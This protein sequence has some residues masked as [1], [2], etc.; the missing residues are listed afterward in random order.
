MDRAGAAPDRALAL[1]MSGGGARAA[2]QV[3]VLR[4]LAR[5]RPAL[6]VS[7]LTG[8]SAGAINAVHLAHHSGSFHEAMESLVSA[9]RSLSIDQVFRTDV[10]YLS[11]NVLR[12][13]ARLLSGGGDFAPRTRGLVDTE[14]LRRFLCNALGT[15]DGRLPGIRRNIE[16]GRLRAVAI[17]T[18][19]YAT[20]QSV[21]WCE[22][23]AVTPWTRPHRQSR[24]AELTV[25]HVMASTALPLIFPAVKLDPEW[26]GDGDIRLTAPLAPALHLGADRIVAVSTRYRRTQVEVDRPETDA[27]YPPPAQVVGVLLNSVFLDNFDFD[28][29]QMERI[30]ALIRDLPLE[31]RHDLRPVDLQVVRPSKDLGRLAHEYEK[32]LPRA[33]R[34]LTRGLGTQ[35]TS[36]SDTLSF[37]LFERPYIERLIALGEVDAEA[38]MDELVAFVDGG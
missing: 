35:E 11:G 16:S 28:A 37:L 14:P 27:G 25:E 3:G 24:T 19:N 18:T 15:P 12:W 7:I 33:F 4:A 38:R 31:R 26:H 2:F 32:T 9:W 23:A 8:V 1:V 10:G 5:R 36:S 13:A 21:T 6:P 29:L 30:N 22:G 20:A 17:S 34:F